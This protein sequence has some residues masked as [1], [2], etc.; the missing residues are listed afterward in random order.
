MTEKKAILITGGC[1]G[2]GGYLA[3]AFEKDGYL[4]IRTSRKSRKDVLQLDVRSSESI[5]NCLETIDKL[6]QGRLYAIINNAGMGYF[7]DFI[8]LSRDDLRDQFEVNVFGLHELTKGIIQIFKRINEG[9]IINIGSIN[10]KISFSHAGAYSASKHALEALTDSLRLEL[11]NTNI[12]ISLIEPSSI[13]SDFRKNAI[14]RNIIPREKPYLKC[15]SPEIT[16]RQVKHALESKNP[17][18]RYITIKD[19]VLVLCRQILPDL[20]FDKIMTTNDKIRKA[21]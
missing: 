5:N 20:I 11:K 14:W 16:Y 3:D 17:L 21:S 9:R 19:R 12:K 7:G 18:T 8:D 10:G 6:T 1:S 4:V 2:I 13:M 15:R